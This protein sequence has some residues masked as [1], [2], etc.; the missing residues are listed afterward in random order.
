MLLL[1][2][3][4]VVSV[5]SHLLWSDNSIK[6]SDQPTSVGHPVLDH[7][8]VPGDNLAIVQ[9]LA[10]LDGGAIIVLASS[11]SWHC[12]NWVPPTQMTSEASPFLIVSI[13][14]WP[15]I[16]VLVHTKNSGSTSTLS[17]LRATDWK[18]SLGAS[19]VSVPP[20]PASSWTEISSEFHFFCQ[21]LLGGRFW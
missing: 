11:L 10:G 7:T 15:W 2:I 9:L 17:K 19:I 20:S 1:G 3:P 4:V 21:P 18:R 16:S 14:C 13:L 8:C 12:S 5:L 6:S